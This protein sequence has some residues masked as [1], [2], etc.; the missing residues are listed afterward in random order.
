MLAVVNLLDAA[1]DQLG[2][3]VGRPQGGRQDQAGDQEADGEGADRAEQIA[4]HG[5][6]AREGFLQRIEEWRGVGGGCGHGVLSVDPR[7]RMKRSLG[8]GERR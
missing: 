6:V 8:P 1:L 3:A 4:Q 5:L 7:Q 2:D